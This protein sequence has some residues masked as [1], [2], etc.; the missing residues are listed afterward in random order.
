M[1]WPR[2]S[3]PRGFET[4]AYAYLRNAWHCYLRW[5]RSEKCGNWTSVT[6]GCREKR[7]RLWLVTRKQDEQATLSARTF[8]RDPQQCLD[9]LI[10]D[11]LAGHRLR[12]PLR[13]RP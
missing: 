10:E 3:T 1:S 7:L 4:I 5:G 11:D 13:T 9:K 6:S 8:D 2:A 12:R